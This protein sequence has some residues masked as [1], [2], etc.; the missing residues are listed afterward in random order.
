[1]LLAIFMTISSVNLSGIYAHAEEVIPDNEVITEDNSSVIAEDDNTDS[2]ENETVFASETE[3]NEETSIEETTEETSVEETSTEEITTIEELD[4]QSVDITGVSVVDGVATLNL[5]EISDEKT[6]AIIMVT[7][8]G[9]CIGNHDSKTNPYIPFDK[10]VFTGSSIS[11]SIQ[12]QVASLPENYELVLDNVTVVANGSNFFISACDTNLNI[13]GELNVGCTGNYSTYYPFYVSAGSNLTING[14]ANIKWRAKAGTDAFVYVNGINT[15]F[16][17][18]DYT[19]DITLDSTLS[20]GWIA[21]GSGDFTIDTS[22]DVKI[23]GGA[24]YTAPFANTKMSIKA[25]NI[26]LSMGGKTNSGSVFFNG[27]DF[28]L[29]AQNDLTITHK[30]NTPFCQSNLDIKAKNLVINMDTENPKIVYRQKGECNIAVD[31]MTINCL[32]KATDNSCGLFYCTNLNIN[33]KNNITAE[34]CC[35]F[36]DLAGGLNMSADGKIDLSFIK[37]SAAGQPIFRAVTDTKITGKKGVSIVSASAGSVIYGGSHIIIESDEDVLI[38]RKEDGTSYTS[39]TPSM[40]LTTSGTFLTE[41]G[42]RRSVIDFT[43]GNNLSI[44]DPLAIKLNNL[45]SPVINSNE[46]NLSF[47]GDVDLNITNTGYSPIF[48][49]DLNVNSSN[50]FN[51][52]TPEGKVSGMISGGTFTVKGASAVNLKYNAPATSNAPLWSRSDFDVLGPINIEIN[53]RIGAPNSLLVTNATDLT[54]T[55]NDKNTTEFETPF[56]VVQGV[57]ISGDFKVTGIGKRYGLSNTGVGKDTYV[58]ARTIDIQGNTDENPLVYGYKL[59]FVADNINIVNEGSYPTVAGQVDID[60]KQL[61]VSYNVTENDEVILGYTGDV[62]KTTSIVV[63]TLYVVDVYVKDDAHGVKSKDD[64]VVNAYNSVGEKYTEGVDYDVA[65][66]KSKSGL[67][68]YD[69]IS[70][71][72]LGTSEYRERYEICKSTHMITAS[73]PVAKVTAKGRD[74]EFSDFVNALKYA[75][76]MYS[77]DGAIVTLLKDVT[78]AECVQLS[79]KT[80]IDLNGHT[81]SSASGLRIEWG[82]LHPISGELTIKDTV[83][84]GCIQVNSSGGGGYGSALGAFGNLLRIESGEIKSTRGYAINGPGNIEINGGKIYGIYSSNKN[85]EIKLSGGELHPSLPAINGPASSPS[86]YNDYRYAL[87]TE[88]SPQNV[89]LYGGKFVVDKADYGLAALYCASGDV[90]ILEDG[91]NYKY[92]DGSFFVFEN[93]GYIIL[94]SGEI[95]TDKTSLPTDGLKLKCE[96]VYSSNTIEDIAAMDQSSRD[97]LICSWMSEYP[98]ASEYEY[99]IKISQ[100]LDA[101]SKPMFLNKQP[102]YTI[103]FVGKNKNYGQLAVDVALINN[104]IEKPVTLTVPCDKDTT[105]A[106]NVSDLWISAVKVDNLKVGSVIPSKLKGSIY[107]SDTQEIIDEDAEENMADVVI[108][109]VYHNG[110]SVTISY[111]G[112]GCMLPTCDRT[113]VANEICDAC[114][115]VW[116][117]GVVTPAIGHDWKEV[118]DWTGTTILDYHVKHRRQCQRDKSHIE[119]LDIGLVLREE[120]ETEVIYTA[121]KDDSKSQTTIKKE[122]FHVVLEEN[123]YEYTGEQIKP[124]VSVFYGTALLENGKDYT[125]T[126]SNNIKANRTPAGEV[127]CQGV[128]R[129]TKEAI[130]L[131]PTIT[132][133]GKGNYS[134]T[135]TK[136]FNIVQKDINKVDIKIADAFVAP[137]ALKTITVISGITDGKKKLLTSEYEAI[138]CTAENGVPNVADVVSLKGIAEGK[139]AAVINGKLNYCGTY[140]KIFDVTSLTLMSTAKVVLDKNTHKVTS[141]TVARKTYKGEELT[142]FDITYP[143]DAVASRPGTHQVKIKA[144]EELASVLFEDECIASYTVAKIKLNSKWFV[145]EKQSVEFD[146]SEKQVA[147][148]MAT[149]E[150]TPELRKGSDKD[151]TVAYKNNIKAGRASVTITGVN[152]YTGTVTLNFNITKPTLTADNVEIDYDSEVP[153]SK[154]GAVQNNLVIR[155]NGKVIPE[156][157]YTVA[158]TNNRVLSTDSVK[159][160]F[161]IKS[162]GSVIF[163]TA[164]PIKKTFDVVPKSLKSDDISVTIADVAFSNDKVYAQKPVVSEGNTKLTINKDY[165]VTYNHNNAY[166]T[167]EEVVEKGYVKLTATIQGIGCY[168]GASSTIELPY[169]V[170]ADKAANLKIEIIPEECVFN[171]D[172]PVEP[173]VKVYYGVKVGLRTIYYLLPGDEYTVE[174]SNNTKI[175][176]GTVKVTGTKKYLGSKTAQFKIVA[177]AM[178][179]TED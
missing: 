71:Y 148:N 44:R 170:C 97:E 144:G 129:I 86:S 155:Y 27:V 70:F 80:I 93:Q 102:L 101:N 120:N 108:S 65:L 15:S 67:T 32:K 82:M 8:W 24:S 55:C 17:I 116:N 2:D 122:G 96:Y 7:S 3:E 111:E 142:K 95:I 135:I 105:Y 20:T 114:G 5:E 72:L 21:S 62:M 104:E 178:A 131:V 10:L 150:G 63:P 107:N 22:G 50:A 128:D 29:D 126:Y 38:E 109:E 43:A 90:D 138:Y 26:D 147:V 132:I 31:N 149:T 39:S 79:G 157:N 158:Y 25:K 106:I 118:W 58:K 121:Q 59:K 18:K 169:R 57:N 35:M 42:K 112:D 30:N 69:A 141:I 11:N 167:A 37:L 168:A 139:Y 119:E 134:S 165:K 127:V 123:D 177:K 54:F 48:S 84:T 156:G 174:Y 164:N 130:E 154:A 4:L 23:S 166:V 152:E 46:V 52:S 143:D 113:G 124:V 89:H 146:G 151:F 13:K 64:I 161:T 159:A 74:V 53:G 68:D 160:S 140:I 12:I 33:A 175:G 61:N 45:A 1:M 99:D 14:D 115:E 60:A 94:K 125:V 75:N 98:D 145:L 136:S 40:L 103:K 34:N 6:D 117:T 83:G 179:F 73:E 133:K 51:Y 92:E 153:F 81:I 110:K 78:M 162:K 76:R 85:G 77:G 176:R 91:F 56:I 88:K 28:I 9:F 41:D 87:R 171:G 172:K 66:I 16:N 137:T 36:C 100:K 173:D 47:E 19:G 49:G 163:D